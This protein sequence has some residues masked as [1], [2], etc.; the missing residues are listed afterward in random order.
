ML[1]TDLVVHSCSSSPKKISDLIFTNNG[2]Y[3]LAANKFGDV[4]AMC[5]EAKE[6]QYLP[7]AVLMGHFCSI[8]TCISL[9]KY[10]K[11]EV[12]ATSDRDGRVRI[13][14]LPD[15]PMEGAHEIQ[16]YCFGHTKFVSSAAFIESNGIEI[17]V[18][19]GGDG[20]LKVWD[21]DSGKEIDS[22]RL[23]TEEDSCAILKILP[24]ADAKS[25]IVIL[26]GST[27]IRR[28]TFEN[29]K[30]QESEIPI[31]VRVLSD[32]AVDMEGMFWFVGGPIGRRG[33]C[34]AYGRIVDN[35]F[36][37][38]ERK[39]DSE[40]SLEDQC[41]GEDQ[42]FSATFLPEYLNKQSFD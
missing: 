12:F 41:Q 40:I 21:I 29:N 37:P 6:G 15:N 16:S 26:D 33:I 14:I 17:I 11:P 9:S 22:K 38:V 39:L 7:S 30:I 34:H 24:S 4:M 5:T 13:S 10:H 36:E 19:G 31:G 42:S 8:I 32:A 25:A 28:I 35:R 1:Q 2:Q 20:C 23:S 27:K 3:I 18:T